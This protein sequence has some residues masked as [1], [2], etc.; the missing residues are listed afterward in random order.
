MSEI[1]TAA[2]GTEARP[3]SRIGTAARYLWPT[4]LAVAMSA[5]TWGGGGDTGAQVTSLAQAF[6]LLPLLYLLVAKFQWRRGTWAV[7][8]VLLVSFT[9]LEAVDVVDPAGVAAAVALAVLVWGAADGRLFRSGE[10]QAQALAMIGFGAV[11]L[12]GLIA[13]PEAGRYIVAAGWFLHGIWDLVHLKLDKV[14]LRSYAL[15]CGVIDVLIA[16]QLIFFV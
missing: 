4:A 9:A 3:T 7:L 8:A 2:P 1:G 10:L 6:V 5:A 12:A 11:A 14:V 13:D 16:A 15:W